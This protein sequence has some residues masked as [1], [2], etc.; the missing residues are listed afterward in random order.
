[1]KKENKVEKCVLCGMCRMVCPV[2]GQKKD[3]KY[4][5]RGKA[6]IIKDKEEP[7]MSFYDCTT[8]GACKEQCHINVDLP[9][10]KERERLVRSGRETDANKRMIANIRKYGNPFGKVKK[11]EVPL[12]LYCC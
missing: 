10:L 5:P 1:M 4:S 2:F 7:D 11:G 12:E 3:E 8:C 6:A 9:I